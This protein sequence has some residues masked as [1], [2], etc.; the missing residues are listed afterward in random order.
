M[1]R[2]TTRTLASL[3]AATL[4]TGGCS[5]SEPIEAPAAEAPAAQKAA[6]K[7]A[8]KT[9]TPERAAEVAAGHA[10]AAAFDKAMA[11]VVQPYLKIQDAL[12]RDTTEGVAEAAK[13]IGAAAAKLEPGKV[14]GKHAGHYTDVPS[15]L[16]ESAAA[17]AGVADLAA[18]REA[19]KGLS[20][21][22]G[23]WAT[24][25][26]PDGI[27]L[28]YCPMAKGSWL[29][30]TGDI[31]NPYHGSEMLACGEVVSGPGKEEGK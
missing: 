30:K 6:E 19:F 13:A 22:L 16:A 25:A 31:R 28:V 10:G 7:T 29:Q 11:D 4:L 24:M 3:L 2:R 27:D 21:P 8:E 17:L 5:K 14:T 15:K 26:K 9:P 12:A 18:A 20:K 1:T 23:M